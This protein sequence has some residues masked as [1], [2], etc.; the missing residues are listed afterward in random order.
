MTSAEAELYSINDP[1]LTQL[2]MFVAITNDIMGLFK[3][4]DDL[5]KKKDGSADL[6]F[7]RMSIR[8]HSFSATD[9]LRLHTHKLNNCIQSF[10]FLTCTYPPLH[11]SFYTK[12]LAFCFAFYDFHSKGICDSS[13][14][15]YGWKQATILA[16]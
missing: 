16:P 3:D 12:N 6:N 10:E 14:N 5:A 11:Q 8:D 9:A 13:N 2:A 1:C 15:R 7:V 4:L